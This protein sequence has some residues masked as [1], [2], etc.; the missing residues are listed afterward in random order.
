M[1]IKNVQLTILVFLGLV[2]LS[3]SV[4]VSAQQNPNNSGNIFLDSDQDG[5]TDQEEKLYGTDSKNPDTDGDG[6]SDGAEVKSG[7]DPTKPAPG[8]KLTVA[9]LSNSE[10]GKVLGDSDNNLTSQVSQKITELVQ[11]AQGNEEDTGVTLDQLQQVIDQSFNAQN[12]QS[13]DLPE[14]KK[15]DFKILKQNYSG[16]SK[17]KQKEKKKEDFMNYAVAVAYILSSNSPKPITSSQDLSDVFDNISQTILQSMEARNPDGLSDLEKSSDKI[18]EQLKQVEVPEE[19]V[20]THIKAVRYALYAKNLSG[21][22]S[23]NINDPLK[24][25]ANFSKISAL[26]QSVQGFASD[27]TDK[28]NEYGIDYNDSELQDKLKDY[29]LDKFKVDLNILNALSSGSTN[30]NSSSTSNPDSNSDTD[31]DSN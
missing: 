18:V 5:L 6:Y 14:V 9:S 29:G 21:T 1:K 8:D 23:P 28:F 25:I 20:D 2:I 24:D 31:S 7:Y 17:D 13:D 10:N 4:Y 3:F 11:N 27:I 12:V 22:L 30:S 26:V 16:L 19:M 15:E